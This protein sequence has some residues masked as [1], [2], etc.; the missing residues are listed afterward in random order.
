MC[1]IDS[2]APKHVNFIFCIVSVLYGV[3]MLCE[4]LSCVIYLCIGR[5]LI[6][7]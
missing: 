4:I 2:L 7:N 5:N 3:S 1:V 6:E